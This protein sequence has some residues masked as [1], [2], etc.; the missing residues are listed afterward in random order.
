MIQFGKDPEKINH[1]LAKHKEFQRT[2]GAKQPNYDNVMR[3]GKQVK[4]RAPIMDEPVLRQMMS[5]MKAKWLSVCNISV[6]RQ[7]KLEEGLLLS[8]HFK[9]AI[10]VRL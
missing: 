3:L 7:R 4:D 2:L 8:G 6:D 10:Q 9:D 5:G 1:L